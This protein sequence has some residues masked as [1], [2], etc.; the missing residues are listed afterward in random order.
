MRV[1]IWEQ[2]SSSVGNIQA[3]NV[4]NTWKKL[5]NELFNKVEQLYRVLIHAATYVEFSK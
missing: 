2:T 3:Q 1:F 4:N 5:N